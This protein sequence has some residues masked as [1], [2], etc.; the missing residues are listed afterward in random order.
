LGVDHN[1]LF[2]GTVEC[3]LRWFAVYTTSRHEKRVSELITNR[4]IETFLPLYRAARQWKKRAPVVLELPLFPNY[5]FVRMA[6]GERSSVFSTPGVL[7]IVGGREPSSLQDFEIE[8]LR[9]G[10]NLRNVEPYPYLAVGERVRIKAGPFTGMDGVL[11]RKKNNL[12][13]V[14]SIEMILQSVAVEI[15][16]EDVEPTTNQMH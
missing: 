10:V 3:A 13:V 12:R 7:S 15:A 8:A 14:L 11:V 2:P 5:V 1:E 16:A 9:S 6:P 4:Q